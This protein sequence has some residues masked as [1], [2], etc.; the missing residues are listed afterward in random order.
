MVSVSESGKFENTMARLTALGVAVLHTILE[1]HQSGMLRPAGPQRPPHRD[2]RRF[3]GPDRRPDGGKGK[4]QSLRRGI[5]VGD[6]G[7]A[8]SL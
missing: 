8:W 3:D 7:I 1:A 6:A 2:A 5:I 4:K